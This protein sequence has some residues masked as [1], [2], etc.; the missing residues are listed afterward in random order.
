MVGGHQTTGSCQSTKSTDYPLAPTSR[1]ATPNE[2]ASR[3]SPRAETAT[4][5][6]LRTYIQ[7]FIDP[8]T[9]AKYHNII[10]RLERAGPK[11]PVIRKKMQNEL[12]D[13]LKEVK[14]D[15]LVELHNEAA[16]AHNEGLAGKHRRFRLPMIEK[17][18]GETGNEMDVLYGEEEGKT[19]LMAHRTSPVNA[20]AAKDE[21]SYSSDSS[22]FLETG[23]DTDLIVPGQLNQTGGNKSI[24]QLATH[25]E[26]L[27]FT[28]KDVNM[29]ETDTADGPTYVTAKRSK[30]VV[31]K[32]NLPSTLTPKQLPNTTKAGPSEGYAIPSK[33]TA[34]SA[35]SYLAWLALR[36]VRWPK[37]PPFYGECVTIGK[38]LHRPTPGVFDEVLYHWLLETNSQRGDWHKSQRLR[39]LG[40]DP[41]LDEQ[42]L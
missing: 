24:E 35:S 37:V 11:V 7:P 16:K 18:G 13:L 8:A 2:A 32:L 22:G 27:P 42:A 25:E 15:D 6:Y 4:M 5:Q 31:L 20:H 28:T 34:Q 39:I 10:E 14:D 23:T 3:G 26:R 19:K 29:T 41:L 9:Y 40:E 21:E 38:K 30:I 12:K 36:K 17:K 1:A 33:V